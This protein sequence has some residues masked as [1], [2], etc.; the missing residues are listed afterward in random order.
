MSLRCRSYRACESGSRVILSL[1]M[2]MAKD[3]PRI[4][5][6]YSIA[7]ESK[8][9]RFARCATC[10]ITEDRAPS[11]SV[12]TRPDSKAQGATHDTALYQPVST[13]YGRYNGPA[14]Q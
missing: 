14:E 9:P 6:V 2:G 8:T 7:W 13:V 3:Y 12:I 5:V 4:A 11:R 10:R 1:P